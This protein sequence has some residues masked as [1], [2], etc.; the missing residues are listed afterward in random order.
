M[1]N[2]VPPVDTSYQFTSPAEAVATKV[3]VP[4]LQAEVAV[5][6]VIVGNVFMVAIIS[7]LGTFGQ[8]PFVVSM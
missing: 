1:A 3:A 6:D 2:I 8:L 5:V 4:E 7:V